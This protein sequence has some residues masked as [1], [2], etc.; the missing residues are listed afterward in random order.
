[1]T[2]KKKAWWRLTHW[3]ILMGIA[4]GTGFGILSASLGWRDFTMN[5]IAPWGDAFVNFLRLIAVPL[6]ITSIIGGIASLRDLQKLS[7]IGF[8]SLGLYVI[9]TCAAVTI[10]L[11]LVHLVKPG[12]HLPEGTRDQL[13]AEIDTPK[14]E[15]E[16]PPHRF[17]Q[18]VTSLV[19]TNFFDS[20]SDNRNLLQIVILSVLLGISLALVP[21]PKAAPLAGL[22]MSLNEVLIMFIGLLMKIA[23]LGVF[24]LMTTAVV[25]LGG[26]EPGQFWS[27]LRGI[28]LYG[29][30]VVLG[31]FLQ[32]TL[33]YSFMLIFLAK[34]RIK[35]FAT[36]V[37]PA[38][39][40]AFSTSSS[41]A[42]LP[43]TLKQCE[44]ELGVR[45]EVASFV[46]PLGTTIN[47]D[48][49]A[50]YQAVAT[51]FLAQALD[52][53][54]G[55]GGQITILLMTLLASIG[56]A[57]VPGAGLIMLAIILESVG[58]PAGAIVLVLGLDRILDMLRTVVNVTGDCVIACI[59]DR[60][61]SRHRAASAG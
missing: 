46:L 22:V 11:S 48:G 53:G 16:T 57:A 17:R 12:E 4:G 30:V 42:T 56:T 21:I 20:I 55:F 34:R 13:V 44:E 3:Q 26:E 2:G 47:M 7:R 23:P 54:I 61:E 37:L 41:A 38:Q 35:A 31:L 29:F 9:S 1:M 40:V 36:G 43:V 8:K 14:A 59:I 15:P 18:M 51:V 50:L 39:L 33:T 24:A 6:V 32:V 52:I 60:S 19:P 5:W 27:L 10:G 25:S 58:V 45:E 49:T 28:G